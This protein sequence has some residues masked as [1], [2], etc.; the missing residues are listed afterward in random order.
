M[1]TENFKVGEEVEVTSGAFA[2]ERGSIADLR[3]FDSVMRIETKGGVAFA[4]LDAAR[5]ITK[6]PV[7]QA[8]RP[9]QAKRR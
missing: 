8:S 3:E 4:L 6:Q 9:L 5:K 1:G 2:G 7:K